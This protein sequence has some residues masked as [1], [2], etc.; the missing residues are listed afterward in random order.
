VQRFIEKPGPVA[1]LAYANAGDYL[2]NSGIYLARAD[3]LLAAYA[4]H[5]PDISG[6]AAHA[7][8]GASDPRAPAAHFYDAIRRDSFEK[9]VLEKLNNIA[10]VKCE[11]AWSDI[12]SWAS[13]WETGARDANGNMCL[14]SGSGSI[15]ARGAENCLIHAQKRLV[16]CIGVRDI[17]IV[18]TEDAILIADKNSADSLRKIATD[19][20]EDKG[21]GKRRKKTV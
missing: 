14:S 9:S 21:E 2:W 10:V 5:A 16:A 4:V 6:L 20:Q 15:I 19:L 12:G 11:M 7:L 3:A 8:S 1:A 13:L 18:E 17:V